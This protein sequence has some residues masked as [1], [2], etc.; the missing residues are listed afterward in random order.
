[1]TLFKVEVWITQ[2]NGN[3]TCLISLDS[4]IS[5]SFQANAFSFV[6]DQSGFVLHDTI[7]IDDDV[8]DLFARPM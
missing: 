7:H 6:Q 3:Q 2:K 1:M 8:L 4:I 5:F